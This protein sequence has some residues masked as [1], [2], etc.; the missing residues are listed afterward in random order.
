M[1][2]TANHN[3]ANRQNPLSV[4]QITQLVRDRIEALPRIWLSGEISNFKAAGSGH[5]Y[6]SLKDERAQIRANMWRSSAQRVTFRPRDGMQVL[7]SGTLSV[8][9]PRGEYNLIVDRIEE[10]GLGKLR[11]EFERLKLQL[12]AEGLFDAEHKKPLPLL[13][14][15]I[16]IVTSPTGAAIRDMLRV[17]HHRHGGLHVLIYPARVQG[18][19][20]AE[21]V[22][23]GV[24]FLDS[25]GG[26]D[27]II[28]GRGGGSEED[29]W[30][31]NEE[32]LARAVFAAKTPIVSAVGHEVDFTIS[33]FV[34]DVR[35]ATPS[36]AA[37]LVVQTKNEYRKTLDSLVQRMGRLMQQRLLYYKSRITISESNPIFVRVRS[38]INE[39]GRAVSD[40]EYRMKQAITQRVYGGERQLHR[41]DERLQVQ[42]L[43]N[44][45][46]LL[47]QRLKQADNALNQNMALRLERARQRAGATMARLEDLSPLKI[48]N[49][50]YAVVFD[51]REQVVR[52]P[53]AVKVG[54]V[55]KLRLAEGELAA[56]V[57]EKP[58]EQVQDELF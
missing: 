27:V 23:E 26:C 46:N 24:Q 51:D 48:L 5:W 39:A 19:G 53:G 1:Y 9:P 25:R 52:R 47:E 15:K 41:L 34:A 18:Q 38:R 45:L 36:N 16:G 42:R 21:E 11:A 32:V 28:I 3:G 6:F 22:A 44:R 12:R 2:P 13:P 20:A 58:R 8:Y 55:L 10:M 40:A 57:I 37:E 29:L 43:Q 49:R 4:S 33:D 50:G 35:A 7:V 17:L 30:A 31:F 56:R 14:T 54:S